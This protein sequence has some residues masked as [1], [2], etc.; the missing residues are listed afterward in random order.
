[1]PT[2]ST[3]I[4]VVEICRKNRF[5]TS[6]LAA[7]SNEQSTQL[8]QRPRVHSVDI[9]RMPTK[10]AQKVVSYQSKTLIVMSNKIEG[11]V[12]KTAQKLGTAV[13]KG[14]QKDHFYLRHYCLD[15]TSK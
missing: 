11:Q 9:R 7:L 13:F 6:L 1:M 12:M 10:P 5:V 3:D 2:E 8:K 14:K 15:L 4:P